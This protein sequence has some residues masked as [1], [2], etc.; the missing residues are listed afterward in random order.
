MPKMKTNKSVA[1][2]VK[3]TGNGKVRRY[4]PGAS[5]LKSTKSSKQLRSFRK[6][7]SVSAAFSKHAKK[8]MG[9]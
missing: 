3:V 5:H 8:M 6:K 9:L 1:K 4:S 7:K 2:R